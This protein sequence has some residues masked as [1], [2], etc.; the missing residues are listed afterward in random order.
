MKQTK[1]LVILA[2]ALGAL[3]APLAR[4]QTAAPAAAASA[5][6]TGTISGRVQN[7]VTGNFLNN[8]RVSVKGTDIVAYTDESGTYR[9]VG[10]PGGNVTL[11]V[12]YTDLDTQ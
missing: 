12:F 5:Q 10:V 8:A 7:V 11:E 1:R 2:L 9:L 4:A 6:S 3:T